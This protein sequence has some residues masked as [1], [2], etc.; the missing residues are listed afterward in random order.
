LDYR[1]NI[2]KN[3]HPSLAGLKEGS[4]LE[5]LNEALNRLDNGGMGLTVKNFIAGMS[6]FGKANGFLLEV[7][8]ATTVMDAFPEAEVKTEQQDGTA[9]KPGDITVISS[10]FR[11]DLQCKNILNVYSEQPLEEF[12]AWV[13]ANFQDVMPGY[14]LGIQPG[15]L[16]AEQ[17][18]LEL[19]Q[20]F[21]ANWQSIIPDS[22]STTPFVDSSGNG[23]VWI[24]LISR[25]E[26]GI[27][28][29]LVFSAGDDLNFVQEEDESRVRRRI[30][31]RLT[32]A[33]STFGFAAG[34][35][36]FNF[37]VVDFPSLNALVDEDS[38]I[39]ALYGSETHVLATDGSVH[40]RTNPDGIYHTERTRLQR[41][42]GV[43]YCTARTIGQAMCTIFPNYGHVQSCRTVWDGNGRFRITDKINLMGV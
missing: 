37:V 1:P 36:Q 24:S 18:F 10:M 34:P 16:A 14:L 25:D 39:T 6:N 42:S 33:Y 2:Q 9:T 29:G 43:I 32:Q 3:L 28:E 13:E 4:G 35:Q 21:G 15:T 19:R 38:V 22:E 7:E 17:T 27:K 23:K 5:W 30:S 41:C 31:N 40:I 26:K 8:V 20:W 12:I 11:S